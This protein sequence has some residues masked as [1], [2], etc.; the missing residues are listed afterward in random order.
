MFDL[1]KE[2]IDV[3]CD[4]G[5]KHQASYQDVTNAK[6]IKC[7]CGILIQLKDK[8]GSVRRTTSDINKAFKDFENTLKK[9]GR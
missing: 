6:T 7:Q 3:K 5:R 8:N 1:R 2:K 9:F 4:C